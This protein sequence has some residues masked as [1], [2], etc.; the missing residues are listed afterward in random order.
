VPGATGP[1]GPQGI[2]GETGQAAGKIFYHAPSDPSDIAGYGTLLPSPSAGPEQTIATVASGT[3][4]VLVRSFAT[5]P[6]VPGAVDYPAGTAYRRFYAMVSGGSARLHLQIFKR[7]VAG[8]ETLVRDE[9][10]DPFISTAVAPQMWIAT[11][12]AAGALLATDRIV[13]KLYA[14]RVSGPTNITVTTFYEGVSHASQIQTT[15]TAGAA[16]PVGP[17]GPPGP[18]G[19][20]T[21][22]VKAGN[23]VAGDGVDGTV[24]LNTVTM[25]FWGPKASG[26][27]P[28]TAFAKALPI[29][30]TWT[31]VVA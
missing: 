31:D 13:A 27:W 12:S 26:A 18:S 30:P 25:E 17:Q 16:G 3:S 10:S 5:D 6:G 11:A 1:Q 21:F 20:S 23:P 7:D 22:M 28:S 19:A 15:I 29:N 14:Q 2:Q 9:Y 8:T 24:L 4:D